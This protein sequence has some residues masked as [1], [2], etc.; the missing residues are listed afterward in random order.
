[1]KSDSPSRTA[2]YVAVHRAAHQL[3]DTPLILNDPI[4]MRVIDPATAFALN[5]NPEHQCAALSISPFRRAF[6][7]VRSRYA[8]D[9]L[10]RAVS[11]GCRQYVILGAGLDTFS[12]RCPHPDLRIFEIDHPATQ[13]YKIARLRDAGLASHK[14]V[15]FYPADFELQTIEAI[16]RAANVDL[17][18]RTFFSWL[19]VTQY[20]KQEAIMAT[21]KYVASLPTGTEMVFDYVLSPELHSATQRSIFD[22]WAPRAAASDEPFR[23]FFE[24]AEIAQKCLSLGFTQTEDISTEDMNSRYCAGRRDGLKVESINR[25]FSAVV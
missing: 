25:L 3:L 18:Q 5:A 19:G 22:A 17:N 15:N 8:E 24:P 10:A 2:E 7:A 12:A 1:M 21:L 11:T 14:W 13:A 16:L 4:A 20:L 23:S 9:Q 6:L